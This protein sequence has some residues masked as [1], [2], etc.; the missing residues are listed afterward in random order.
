M[1]EV[2]SQHRKCLMDC[3]E[4]EHV[5]Q[6]LC[7]ANSSSFAADLEVVMFDILQAHEHC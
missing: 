6:V 1:A 7:I 5:G 3:S 4:N 2:S